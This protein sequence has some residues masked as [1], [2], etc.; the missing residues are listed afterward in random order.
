MI[1]LW[2]LG[3][4]AK[5][6]R[7][8]PR[9]VRTAASLTSPQAI[10]AI[11]TPRPVLAHDMQAALER[12]RIPKRCGLIGKKAGMAPWFNETGEKIPCTVLEFEAVE[13]THVRK[14]ETDGLFAVQLG[15]GAAKVAR[16]TR[17]LLGHFARAAVNPKQKVMEFLVRDESGLLP[18][19]TQLR[20]DHF[21]VGQFVDLKGIS[22]GK[23]FAGVMKRWGFGGQPASHGNSKAHRKG[24]SYGAN[25]DPGRTIPGR[26]MPGRMGGKNCTEQNSQIVF[27]DAEK[28]YLLVKGAVPGPKGGYV[29]VQDAIKKYT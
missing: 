17:Q 26:K 2:S 27:V 6:L 18:L 12:K 20:A 13:V 9:M 4:P 11:E 29:K 28:G 19:G 7:Q 16:V 8:Y 14:P 25:Q 3:V 1:N 22:K 10:P 23:G 21:T 15:Y 5:T 24:G